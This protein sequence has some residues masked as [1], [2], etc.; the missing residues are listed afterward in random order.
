MLV[1]LRVLARCSSL[2][3]EATRQ[4]RDV[5]GDVGSG[6]DPWRKALR[7]WLQGI[8]LEDDWTENSYQLWDTESGMRFHPALPSCPAAPPAPSSP[9]QI[10]EDPPHSAHP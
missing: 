9:A 10:G 6:V 5:I 8:G 3:P 4:I 2:D 7:V 1:A